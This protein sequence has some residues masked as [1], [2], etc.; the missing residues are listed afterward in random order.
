MQLNNPPT[1]LS[2]S[3]HLRVNAGGGGQFLEGLPPPGGWG[4]QNPRFINKEMKG[5]MCC[6][7]FHIM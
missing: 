3:F 5:G 7:N 1:F 2:A 6:M 4:V